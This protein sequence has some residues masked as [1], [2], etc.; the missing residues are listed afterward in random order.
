MEPIYI[1]GILLSE[2]NYLSLRKAYRRALTQQ[3]KEFMWKNTEWV[4]DFI[5]YVLETMEM[6]PIIKPLIDK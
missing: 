5:K 4:V 6:N 2:E 3:K 1:G